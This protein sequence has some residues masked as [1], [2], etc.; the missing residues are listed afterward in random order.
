MKALLHLSVLTFLLALAASPCFAE[1]TIEHVSK[2][3]AKE[4]GMEIRSNPAGPDAVRVVLEFQATGELKNF[5]RVDMG[6]T[7]GG[8]LLLASSLKEEKSKPGHVVVSFAADRANL[9]KITLRVVVSAPLGGAGYDLRMK[10]F[11]KPEK[12]A[13]A[14]TP[15]EEARFLAEVRKAFAARD[16]S[17]LDALTC[18]D[19]VPAKLKEN[20]QAAYASLVAEQ[21][22]VFDFKLADPDRK[23][24]DRD[25]TEEGVTYRANLPVTRQLNMKATDPRDKKTL[26]ILTFAVGEKDGKLFLLG[27]AP[28]E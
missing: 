15:E 8:K 11:V 27:S 4:L 2:E 20:L 7:E 16:A 25:R 5:S 17:G 3:R 14:A 21:G 9:K 18:W 1:M 26:F 22:V 19:R 23:F 13:G 28:V 24:V 10:D 12:A 6:I